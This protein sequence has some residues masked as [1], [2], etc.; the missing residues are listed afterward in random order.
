MHA[1]WWWCPTPVGWGGSCWLL[2]HIGRLCQ[3]AQEGGHKNTHNKYLLVHAI[4]IPGCVPVNKSRIASPGRKE[5]VEF[6]LEYFSRSRAVSCNRGKMLCIWPMRYLGLRA[7]MSITVKK[8]DVRRHSPNITKFELLRKFAAKAFACESFSYA[9]N[10]LC[11]R[12]LSAKVL[13]KVT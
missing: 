8:K 6:F 1:A 12:L 11:E 2:Q 13:A 10:V 9:A 7:R 3:Q 5:G 4:F